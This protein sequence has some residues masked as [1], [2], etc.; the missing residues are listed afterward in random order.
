MT[1]PELTDSQ[2]DRIVAKVIERRGNPAHLPQAQLEFA[3]RAE[4][5]AMIQVL[6]VVGEV[7]DAD[8]ELK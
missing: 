6:Y 7:L 4:V 2:L 1:E 8:S 5:T 3:A